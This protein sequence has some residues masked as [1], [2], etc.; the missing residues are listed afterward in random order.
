LSGYQQ[1]PLFSTFCVVGRCGRTARLGVGIATRAIA[2]SA[3]CPHVKASVGAVT[4]Q[5]STD[6]RLGYLAIRLLELGFSAEKVVEELVRSDP[7]NGVRQ[8]GIV[9]RD[10][11]AAA[12]TGGG[13]LPWTGHL[14]ASNVVALG[15]YLLG[16]HVLQAMFETFNVSVVED[17]EERLLRALEAGRDAGG[18]HGGQHS[19]G[20]LV[21]DRA[22][23]PWV[24]LR[25][26]EHHEPIGELR[27]VFE[28][29]KPLREYFNLRPSNPQLGREEDWLTGQQTSK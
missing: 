23:Y 13:T 4:T 8:L 26:D 3:R 17:L 5:A 1:G 19:A 28:V 7:H 2:V 25:V 24:D 15:N 18:Q 9:D 10:G 21:Y 27:R 22:E 12:F 11:N 29:Y 14:K 16:S 6:P 20:L